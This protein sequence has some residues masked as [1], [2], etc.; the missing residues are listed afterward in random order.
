MVIELVVTDLDGTLWDSQQMVAPETQVALAEL[1]RRNIPVLA[2]TA[3]RTSMARRFFDKNSLDLPVLL[4]NGALGRFS[5][6][7]TPF[8][9]FPIPSEQAVA[10]LEILANYELTPFL[11]LETRKLDLVSTASNSCNH[12]Y[13]AITADQTTVVDSLV[14]VCH[15]YPI[16]NLS[17]IGHPEQKVLAAATAEINEIPDVTAL[18]YRDAFYEGWTVNINAAQSTKW[19]GVRKFSAQLGIDASRVLSI[20]DG[21]NDLPLFESSMFSCAMAHASERALAA[22]DVVLPSGDNAWASILDYV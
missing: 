11:S 1:K 8:Y 21:D 19:E 13:L 17:I 4:L 3:R 7:D 22:A 5:I 20:G 18:F 16:Y 12:E 14:D 15:S 6:N 2:A 9:A 10:V